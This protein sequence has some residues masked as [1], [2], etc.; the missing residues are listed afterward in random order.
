MSLKSKPD[1]ETDSAPSSTT[2]ADLGQGFSLQGHFLLSMPQLNGSYFGQSLILLC[3]HT[4]D[5]ALGLVINKPSQVTLADMLEEL[6][7]HVPDTADVERRKV[8]EGGP[9]ARDRG[10]VLHRSIL[11]NSDCLRLASDLYLSGAT[12]ALDE[13]LNDP[14]QADYMVLLGYAGWGAGQLEA[15][16]KD[17]SWLTVEAA[18]SVVFDVQA[19]KRL[20]AAAAQLGIDYRLLANAGHA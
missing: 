2:T 8:L 15:E 1:K 18:S 6:Q 12:A 4:A 14:E 5:G 16:L 11:A 17:N 19:P 3:E 7:L 20:T 9:V 10:F 13:L